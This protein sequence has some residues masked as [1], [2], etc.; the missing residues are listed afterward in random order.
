MKNVQ[1]KKFLKATVC[2]PF[3]LLNK[4]VGKRDDIVL[5]Y[6]ANGG[7]DFN[8]KPVFEYLLTHHYNQHY[9]IYC[10]IR[11]MSYKGTEAFHVKYIS[12]LR[13]FFVLLRSK[14]VFYS[15]GQIPV[16]P[17]KDQ[18]VMHLTHGA[19]YYKTMGH[20][21]NINNGDEYFFNKMITTCEL[22]RPIL[23]KAY[24]CKDEDIFIC[25][26]PMTDV[27]FQDTKPYDLQGYDKVLL[28]L[29]TFRQ[30]EA[31]GYDNSSS[32][33]PLLIFKE[34][35]YEKLNAF[36]KEKN[37]LVIVKLHPA[38]TLSRYREQKYSHLYLYSNTDFV[39]EGWELYPLL[40]Q[41]DALIGDYSSISLQYLLLN[42]PMAFVIPDIEDY[43][44]QRGFV[45]E[46]PMEY[47]PGHK[48]QKK[49]D[50]YLFIEDIA[51]KRDPYRKEREQIRDRIHRYKDGNACRRI[52]EMSGIHE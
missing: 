16:K 48:I 2:K 20:L 33:D 30:S 42:K 13:S 22:F 28:W 15:A 35:D 11:D 24:L 27:F 17:T 8:L 31:L 4:I 7:I 10:G 47:M 19:V 36:L 18:C 32:T 41:V 21:S 46:E 50:F 6:S 5:F 40:K 1:L 23:K 37:I 49:E 26:E 9:K 43:A 51:G 29:P 14:H 34:S 38:Q 39:K 52:L 3:S 12:R 25:N 45:F 44:R